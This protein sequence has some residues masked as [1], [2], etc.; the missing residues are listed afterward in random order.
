M[1]KSDENE[2]PRDRRRSIEEGVDE[3][4]VESINLRSEDDDDDQ[5]NEEG[6]NP[7]RIRQRKNIVTQT[8]SH[9]VN[10][11]IDCVDLNAALDRVD[12]NAVLERIEWDRLFQRVDPNIILQRVRLMEAVVDRIDWDE[13]LL[14][15]VDLNRL[16]DKI[17]IEKV[18]HRSNVQAIVAQSSKQRK[19]EES[20]C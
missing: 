6:E 19:S 5:G 20:K 9:V 13:F 3:A 10:P 17:D 14:E 15:R 12:F 4:D 1:T 7:T 8:V 2:N 16:L 11:V 18:V